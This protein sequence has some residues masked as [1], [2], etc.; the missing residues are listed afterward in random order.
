MRFTRQRWSRN[1][2]TSR[3]ASIRR[4]CRHPCSLLGIP[5]PS[6]M[7]DLALFGLHCFESE[8][9]EGEIGRAG[10]HGFRQP[11]RPSP[12]QRAAVRHA[13][14]ARLPQ[15]IP[16]ASLLLELFSCLE[17]DFFAEH[18]KREVDCGNRAGK[19]AATSAAAARPWQP[20]P[21]SHSCQ[22]QLWRGSFA[23]EARLL[24][25]VLFFLTRSLQHFSPFELC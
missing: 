21:P 8:W 23:T 13:S 14:E 11:C 15:S 22:C 16:L 18:G 1:R 17:C 19:C 5:L 25:S 9:G 24:P 12:A 4:G 3:P 2:S 7:I 10:W 6:P 20:L